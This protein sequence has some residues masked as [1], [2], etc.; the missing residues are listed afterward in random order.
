MSI[1]TRRMGLSPW[2]RSNS[3]R[4]PRIRIALSLAC[5][6][7]TIVAP[8]FAT[9]AR[10]PRGWL[11]AGGMAVF[12]FM[13]KAVPEDA[14]AFEDALN[15]GWD[16][17]LK[18]PM[19]DVIHLEPGM[20]PNMQSLKI[21]LSESKV[22]PVEK[23]EP[24]EASERKLSG[25]SVSIERFE[26]VSH[27]LKNHGARLDL[28]LTANHVRLDYGK[29]KSGRSILLL[30]D[31]KDGQVE[32]EVTQKDL[33]SILL[34]AA[35]QAGEANGVD[36]QKLTL[37]L[38]ARDDH[39]ILL[40]IKADTIVGLI[41]AGLRFTG[42]L[43]IDEHLNGRLSNL[44]CTGDNLLGP[45]ISTLIQPVIERYNNKT[46]PLVRWPKD[47]IQLR[48]VKIS[49]GETIKLTAAFGS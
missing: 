19:P 32:V 27:P 29:D 34:S 21:D 48:A 16:K 23:S 15:K 11:N 31:A 28:S 45:V 46:R 47:R 37:N 9:P 14:A 35:K 10:P 7:A 2:V 18:L 22:R 6:L 33:E 44:T 49:T 40:D 36:V 17:S 12:R 5:L 20:Y 24:L 39:T 25:Q 43:D 41:P 38:T 8:V 13:S 4:S 42:Q 26:L 30:T 1:I 3:C